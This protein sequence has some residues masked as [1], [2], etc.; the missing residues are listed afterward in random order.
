VC[1][2]RCP[3]ADQRAC[4]QVPERAK[5][6]WSYLR[7]H[8]GPGPLN[9]WME[10]LNGAQRSSNGSKRRTRL[11]SGIWLAGRSATRS[12]AHS[13]SLE[14]P[15]VS[16]PFYEGRHLSTPA[17]GP[18]KESVVL[19]VSRDRSGN[20]VIDRTLSPDGSS[21]AVVVGAAARRAAYRLRTVGKAARCPRVYVPS[22]R[23]ESAFGRDSLGEISSL[24]WTKDAK[25][26][27]T[28]AS[29]NRRRQDARTAVKD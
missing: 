11:P 12:K 22:S 28:A 2:D 18:R 23:A 1:S 10:D 16:I 4:L 21:P 8:E 26:F 14:L 6:T 29:R 3:L 20:D 5:A 9:R 7:R 27:S 17:I 13:P 24:A 15:K 25:A 19:R